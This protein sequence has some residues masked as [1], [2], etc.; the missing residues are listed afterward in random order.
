MMVLRQRGRG[1]TG[2]GGSRCRGLPDL[3]SEQFRLPGHA[4]EGDG[5]GVTLVEIVVLLDDEIV[6]HDLRGGD[7]LQ[8]L[9][10]GVDEFAADG[11]GAVIVGFSRSTR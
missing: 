5:D 1:T 11:R 8:P 7:G 3:E 4:R 2:R 10:G 9:D 6:E